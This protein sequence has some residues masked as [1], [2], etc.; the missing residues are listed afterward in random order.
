MPTIQRFRGS[1][2]EIGERVWMRSWRS[3]NPLL[4]NHPVALSTR[5]ANAAIIIGDDV[6]MT[7]TTIVAA[8][9]ISIGNRVM[10]GANST[11]VD[12]DFHPIDWIERQKKPLNGRTAPIIIEDDVFIGMNCLI[13]K[14][15]KIKKGS[16]IGAGSVVTM[17]IPGE[18]IAAGN[19]AKI[20][21][22][23]KQS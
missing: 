15:V 11:I 14:G 3:S 10:I 12:T 4:P 17:D 20:I 8:S 13:L 18:S 2:I 19:P 9:S 23:S 7:G 21:G 5:N 22:S 6:G 16:V 1:Q